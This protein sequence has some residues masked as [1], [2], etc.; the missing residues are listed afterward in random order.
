[1]LGVRG[2]LAPEQHVEAALSREFP[3]ATRPHLPADVVRAAGWFR[4]KSLATVRDLWRAGLRMARQMNTDL[5]TRG[6][7]QAQP[8]HP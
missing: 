6:D 5:G 2:D 3:L 4:G 8:L 7:W 1:M